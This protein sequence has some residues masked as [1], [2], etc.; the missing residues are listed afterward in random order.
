[1]GVT[2]DRETRAVAFVEPTPATQPDPAELRAWW[3]AA[4][5]TYKVPQDVYVIPEM[6]TTVGTNGAKIRAAALRA[7]AEELAN[8][9]PEAGRTSGRRLRS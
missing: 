2:V 9:A 6:P 4:L 8:R 3:S 1:M 5:A 7:L